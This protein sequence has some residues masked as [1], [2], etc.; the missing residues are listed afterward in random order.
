M[1]YIK[2]IVFISEY[3]IDCPK[4]TDFIGEGIGWMSED[5]YVRWTHTKNHSDIDQINIWQS[6]KYLFTMMNIDGII[7][8]DGFDNIPSALK[9]TESTIKSKGIQYLKN[10]HDSKG[11]K[12]NI[13]DFNKIKKIAKTNKTS[14]IDA[15]LKD[16]DLKEKL[17]RQWA[18]EYQNMRRSGYS[19][20]QAFAKFARESRDEYE[21]QGYSPSKTNQLIKKEEKEWKEELKK[22][23]EFCNIV[24]SIKDVNPRAG[25]SKSDFIARFMNET[26]SEYPDEKQ[27]YAVAN[28]YWERKGKDSVHDKLIEPSPQIRQEFEN[29]MKQLGWKI[30]SKQKSLFGGFHYQVTYTKRTNV[31]EAEFHK[32]VKELMDY[33]DRMDD[34]YN[35]D[36]TAN[37]GMGRNGIITAGVDIRE[38]YVKDSLEQK[39]KDFF[40]VKDSGELSAK[41][42]E[43]LEELIENYKKNHPNMQCGEIEKR[44]GLYRVKVD[45]N[46][47]IKDSIQEG[48]IYKGETDKYYTYYKIN[49]I[50]T[51]NNKVAYMFL[52]R[53]KKTG[54]ENGGPDSDKIE[55]VERMIKNMQKVSSLNDSIKDEDIEELS[56]EEKK[57]IE[58]YKKAIAGTTNPKLLEMYS[59]IL[60]EECDH[61][62]ELEESK[63]ME[64]IKD[65]QRVPGQY[66]VEEFKRMGK[67]RQL[68]EIVQNAKRK[69]GNDV[70]KILNEIRTNPNSPY[71]QKDLRD[72]I[73]RYLK[74]NY[75]LIMD[76]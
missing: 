43:S 29:G 58:D 54:K 63:G 6:K 57:A 33:V 45:L 12:M 66:T 55:D 67:D 62:R 53:D 47:A 32:I 50:D 37:I 71:Q 23:L 2:G 24:D 48:D 52:M 26:K 73:S 59:H 46:D 41:T 44:N 18:R 72:A 68:D 75:D 34:K 38:Q 42:I 17:Y 21:K 30:D 31:D 65:Y 14:F 28:S 20:E 16:D 49:K 7:K 8:M 13:K 61:L 56:E 69:F 70:V 4:F 25:E 39:A 10:T 11:V 51:N 40:N 36:N 76:W 27:R 15:I 9:F 5:T 64:S 74:R 3:K 35:T 60:R 22:A 19:K 1:S